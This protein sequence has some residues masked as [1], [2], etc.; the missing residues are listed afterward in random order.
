MTTIL[1][2]EQNRPAAIGDC[3][4]R[5]WDAL[6]PNIWLFAG[7]TLLYYIAS[8]LLT[9]MAF[10][11]PGASLISGLFSFI[12]PVSLYSAFQVAEGGA[13]VRFGDFFN[14]T[15]KFGRLFL[16][17]LIIYAILLALLIPAGL[18]FGFSFFAGAMDYR[19]MVGLGFGMFGLFF[20]IFVI[21]FVFTFALYFL[22]LKKDMSIGE[23]L[24]A[25]LRFGSKHFGQIM[26]WM[27]FAIGLFIAGAI[28]CG[29]GLLVTLPLIVG[30]QYFFLTSIYPDAK[31]EVWDFE[32][33]PGP[34]RPQQNY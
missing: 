1:Y 8:G 11:I 30:M 25:T 19:Y 14:W 23:T 27:L 24:S 6:K 3:L 26:L 15:P 16:G 2:P 10:F 22:L 21:F 17:A 13:E 20:F 34:D 31:R 29:I 4:Q 32:Q 12:L 7:F 28:P 5:A 9:Q 33:T 18:L